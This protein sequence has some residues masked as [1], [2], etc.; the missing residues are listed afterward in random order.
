M[1]NRSP[2][3]IDYLRYTEARRIVEGDILLS[4]CPRLLDLVSKDSDPNQAFNFKFEFGI[5]EFANRFVKGKVTGQLKLACQ[6]CMDVLD[7]PIDIE[8]ALAFIKKKEQEQEIVGLYDSFYVESKDPIDFY[9]LI[10]DEI[11]L[12]LPLIAKHEDENCLLNLDNTTDKK[13]S[14][15]E[16]AYLHEQANKKNPFAVLQQL[17]DSK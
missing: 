8:L 17:K 4:E 5:D 11:I 1:P 10:E 7:Y 15:L 16:E 9:A 6:R 14:E 13:S 3:L 12:S 2:Q